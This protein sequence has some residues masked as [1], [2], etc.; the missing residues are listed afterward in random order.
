VTGV[1][2]SYGGA[3][4]GGPQDRAGA[5][6][7]RQ[8]TGAVR[9]MITAVVAVAAVA[10]GIA[11]LSLAG[12]HRSSLS[13]G[14]T[15]AAMSPQAKARSDSSAFLH[16][17]LAANGRVVRWD[18]GGDTVSEGQAYAM[19]LAVALGRQHQ[20]AAAW[21]WEQSHLR[22]PD[23]LFAYH[24]SKGAVV[25]TQS[26]SDADLDTAWALVL[27]GQRF[28]QPAYRIAG[29]QVA[30]AILSQESTVVAGRLELVAGPWALTGPVV[31]NPSYLAPEAMAALGQ[32]TGDP[33]WSE[34]ASDTT[35]LVTGVVAHDRGGL[36]PNWLD[37]APDG[38]AQ[39]IG[40][41]S[42]SGPAQYGLDAQ[43]APVWLAAGCTEG[44]RRVAARAWPTLDHA[45]KSGAGVSYTLSGRVVGGAV[46]PMGLVAAAA[47]ADASGHSGAGNRLLTQ[48]DRQ[49]DAHH[50]YY[51][52]AWTALGRVLLDTTWLSSCSSSA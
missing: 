50:T 27:A 41:P 51:G 34:L 40:T 38:S 12:A 35:A 29:Q 31:V 28:D 32:A 52:D 3:T 8:R 11:A 36:L 15:A 17:F 49:A 39:P 22:Q 13:P 5:G 19:L 43:R 47:A 6:L 26:A 45:A 20:F 24:W 18:Q 42:G 48:A 9:R 46:N 33:R 7:P 37:L 25:G 14:A 21:S 23:G 10:A 4:I 30:T 16:R 44:D 2:T 1:S